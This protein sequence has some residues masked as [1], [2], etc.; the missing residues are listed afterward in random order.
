[1]FLI[2]S[3]N[4]KKVHLC[5]HILLTVDP[6]SSNQYCLTEAFTGFNLGRNPFNSNRSEYEE[7]VTDYLSLVDTVGVLTTVDDI[8]GAV[9]TK[10]GSILP[11]SESTF[12]V[13]ELPELARYISIEG[14][15]LDLTRI[16][17]SKSILVLKIGDGIDDIK[18][19][20]SV[21]ISDSFIM[22]ENT[23][24]LSEDTI[25]TD[26]LL[27]SLISDKTPPRTVKPNYV[28]DNISNKIWYKRNDGNV[29]RYKMRRLGDIIE[30][31]SLRYLCVVDYTF[32]DNY[33]NSNEF[34]QL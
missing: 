3:Y 22:A 25:I 10:L 26:K 17:A 8:E 15:M 13:M 2:K 7:V 28:K 34:I 9:T 4:A 5:N 14:A 33:E 19:I 24:E 31:G 29:L 32:S 27:N 1:M 20:D 11:T 12:Y 18:V 23:Q 21:G 30:N 16:I 6:S